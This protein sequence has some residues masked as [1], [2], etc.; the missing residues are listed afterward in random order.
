MLD[1]EPCKR[2]FPLFVLEIVQPHVLTA[3]GRL[4]A[5]LGPTNVAFHRPGHARG[6]VVGKVAVA[7]QLEGLRVV[8]GVAHEASFNAL[9]SVAALPFDTRPCREKV[10]GSSSTQFTTSRMNVQASHCSNCW[11]IVAGTLHRWRPA[12]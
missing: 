6:A 5:G 12:S 3:I 2:R 8:A 4:D 11:R 7:V 10:V 1:L 9:P